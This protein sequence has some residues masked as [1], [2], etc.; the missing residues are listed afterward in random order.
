MIL[1]STLKQAWAHGSA[2]LAQA[3]V[4]NAR[5]DAQILLCF[6]M[7]IERSFLYAYPE[8]LVSPE[9][10]YYYLTLIER[11]RL[12][13]PMAYITGHKEFYGLDFC[14][15]ARV[16]I[17]RPETELL[18]EAALTSINRRLHAGKVPIVA[19]IG[20]G[21]GAIAVTIAVTE[22][23]LPYL[24]AC[25]ISA[26]ALEVARTNARHLRVEE[27]VR[28]LQ[29]DLVASLPEAVDLL[30]ANLP[31]VGTDEMA[32]M[33]EDVLAYEPHQ[34]LFSGPDG[35]DLLQ[36][37]CTD[38]KRFGTLNVGGEMILEIGYQQGDIVAQLIRGL[39]PQANVVVRKDY[40]GFDRLVL[41]S[42]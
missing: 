16:L 9:Q 37:L 33:A 27:R 31:Y 1:M 41:V 3:G 34:A 38:V 36:R 5:L 28:F 25:D 13:E 23:R 21:S 22:P 7:R 42:L 4:E 26:D 19:D 29:G 11:R 18:V 12:H 10:A 17:P 30:L 40:A 2:L 32:S 39:W 24:Y 14:V 8:H 20:T 15:D 35:Q 6:A